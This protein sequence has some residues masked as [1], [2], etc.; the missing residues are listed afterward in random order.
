MTLWDVLRET[1]PSSRP[2]VYAL[3][4]DE[5]LNIDTALPALVVLLVS[6]CERRALLLHSHDRQVYHPEIWPSLRLHALPDKKFWLARGRS[7]KAPQVLA[8]QCR[9][10]GIGEVIVDDAG[11]SDSTPRWQPP[12]F[13]GVVLTPE[14][15]ALYECDHPLKRTPKSS[16]C[17]SFPWLHSWGTWDANVH[18]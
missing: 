11:A 17:E 10:L 9:D 1:V 16:V 8:R 2:R 18:P 6:V 4:L 14:R 12:I 3:G 7:L 13:D 5:P 15:T